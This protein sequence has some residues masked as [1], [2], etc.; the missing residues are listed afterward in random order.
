M[1]STHKFKK[2]NNPKL[3]KDKITQYVLVK[4]MKTK[5]KK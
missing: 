5:G 3:N 4:F 2:L 1:M